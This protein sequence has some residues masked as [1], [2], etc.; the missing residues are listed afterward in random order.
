MPCYDPGPS[1]ED[2]AGYHFDHI[3]AARGIHGRLRAGNK[4]EML[5]SWCRQMGKLL[6]LDELIDTEHVGLSRRDALQLL[7]W[8]EDHRSSEGHEAE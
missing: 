2:I 5:C 6:T 3:A 8:W 7:L 1:A 4:V